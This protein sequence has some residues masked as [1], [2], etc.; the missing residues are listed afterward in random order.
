MVCRLLEWDSRFFGHRIGEVT[1][2][3]LESNQMDEIERWCAEQAIDCL[4]LFA[5]V[6]P[7]TITLAE[8]HGFGLKDVRL[9]FHR[10]L[11]EV[12]DPPQREGSVRVARSDDVPLLEAIAE[13]SHTDSRFYADGRFERKKAD[14][15]YR[16]WI[17]NSVAGWADDVLVSLGVADR[18]LGYI[19]GHRRGQ[20]GQIGL[21]AVSEEARGRGCATELVSMLSARYRDAGITAMT[22]VTQ[23]RNVAARRLYQRLG[24]ALDSIRLCY[25]RW[26]ST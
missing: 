17:R 11:R 25:H 20:E 6:E 18:P 21:I 24:F 8:Q 13:R 4:Y 7:R 16:V 23:A 10:S 5:E 1:V 14:E 19:T 9:T 22:V 12:S 3:R 26:R 2:S 15:L